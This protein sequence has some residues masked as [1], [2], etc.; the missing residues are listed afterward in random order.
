MDRYPGKYVKDRI[1]KT[2]LLIKSNQSFK[3]SPTRDKFT[4]N[5]TINIDSRHMRWG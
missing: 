1:N 3:L 4:M 2:V 5:F